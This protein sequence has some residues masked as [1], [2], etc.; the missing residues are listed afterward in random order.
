MTT[1]TI[2]N[3]V[4][5]WE[6][7][8]AVLESLPAALYATDPAG[9][10]VFY[11]QEAA[12]LWGRE[13]ELHTSEWNGSWR[14]FWPDGKPMRHD[15]C[16]MAIAMKE[17]RAIKGAEVIA[18]RPDG[19]RVRVLAYPTPLFDV[20]NAL[21]GAVNMLVDVTD[22]DQSNYS[23][24]R[25]A[26][27]VDSSYDAI[28]SKDMNG[29]ITSWNES[30]EQ[31]YGYMAAEIVGKPVA[32]LIPPERHDEDRAITERVRKGERISPFETVRRRKDGTLVDISLTVSP[33]RNAAGRVVGASKIARDIM[34]QKLAQEHQ[35]LLLG[36]M[37]HRVK[38]VLSVAG[39]LVVLS[40]RTAPTPQEMAKAV[41]NRLA[42]YARAHDL[43]RPGLIDGEFQVENQA[44]LHTL[45]WTIVAPYIDPVAEDGRT[46]IS[47]DGADILLD[48][49]AA[50]NLALILHEFATNAAKYGALSADG[51]CVRIDCSMQDGTFEI[52]WQEFDGPPVNGPPDKRGFG[53]VLANKSIQGQ[54]GGTIMHEWPRE[55]VVITLRIP[56]DRLGQPA[57]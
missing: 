38:N 43:T 2:A 27:I 4:P 48:G 52:K 17:R 50:T 11:N 3:L 34:D 33:I 12:T 18:E 9:R 35:K 24:Q 49:S 20:A 1:G 51:G 22:G 42:A 36:E 29:I 53:S 5:E 46:N 30:A 26:S 32:T 15:Q 40:S 10:I 45:I 23:E 47:I 21:I 57:V 44:A 54:L 13:P 55:G 8:T 19:S 37:S 28:I 31:L 6:L 16:P 7:V 14:L 41:Q 39:G 25:L 56:L